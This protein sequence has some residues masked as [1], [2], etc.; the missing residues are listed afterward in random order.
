MESVF[1]FIK[2]PLPGPRRGPTLPRAHQGSLRVN[3]AEVRV[4]PS[5]SSGTAQRAGEAPDHKGKALELM[6]QTCGQKD[7]QGPKPDHGLESVNS[8][9]VRTKTCQ[10]FLTLESE[11]VKI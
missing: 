10:A 7:N 6:T 11:N 4:Q 3:Q 5:Q 2:P 9:E 8:Q 1:Y